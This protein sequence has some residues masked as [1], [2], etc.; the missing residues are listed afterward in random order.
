MKTV[1]Y[2]TLSVHVRWDSFVYYIKNC[3]HSKV[4]E[5]LWFCT[6]K[7]QGM[8]LCRR[9]RT[10][11][12][13]PGTDPKWSR[14]HKEMGATG[15]EWVLEVSG[16]QWEEQRQEFFFL[17]RKGNL[18]PPLFFIMNKSCIDLWNTLLH[19]MLHIICKHMFFQHQN[20]L[21]TY[22]N[23]WTLVENYKYVSSQKCFVHKRAFKT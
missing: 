18:F 10:V 3:T 20:F 5:N 12:P 22:M 9:E 2:F 11:I 6:L 14:T 17:E 8:I 19:F 7:R 13:F 16:S 23:M 4:N 21:N 1:Y 15:W